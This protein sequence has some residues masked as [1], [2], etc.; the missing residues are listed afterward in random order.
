MEA[1]ARRAYDRSAGMGLAVLR[2]LER[3]GEDA[4]AGR[5]DLDRAQ[6][7][8]EDIRR[9][10]DPSWRPVTV[11]EQVDEWLAERDRRVS[12]ATGEIYHRTKREFARVLPRKVWLG[13]VADLTAQHIEAAVARL[14]TE[15]VSSKGRRRRASTVNQLLRCFRQSLHG[16][17]LSGHCRVNPAAGIRPLPETDSQ[18]RTRFTD[19]EVRALLD[20][21][22]GNPWHG[23]I[24]LAVR[25]G[26]R[27]M[28]CL[29]VTPDQ[30]RGGTLY[31]LPK[32]TARRQTRVEIP[33]AADLAAWLNAQPGPEFFPTLA[34]LPKGEIS[35][36]FA[37]LCD[38]A[39]VP[40]QIVLPCGTPAVRSFHSLR[41][42]FVSQLAEAGIPAD[43]RQSL[44][45]HS[46]AKIHRLY[47][48]HQK[49]LADAIHALPEITAL[50]P[51]G[52]AVP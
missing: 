32:K 49:A 33:L 18:V 25:T 45:G 7:H 42:T 41:H 15:S 36:L 9:L 23:L 22:A 30:L 11:A 37:Q 44:A 31:A 39:G 2:I 24:L 40:R 4:T 12:S 38:R 3:A 10:A 35:R 20:Y 50:S 26:L 27:M 51:V 5:L 29:A 46:D 21:S 28:D 52:Q 34:G 48:H 1:D 43:V 6:M 19:A 8:L 16:A 13:P 14:A 17:V 47:T